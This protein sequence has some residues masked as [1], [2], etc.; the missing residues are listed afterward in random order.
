VENLRLLKAFGKIESSTV[1][2]EVLALLEKQ[3][4]IR[5]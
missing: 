2:K 1:R 3:A 4:G 5:R